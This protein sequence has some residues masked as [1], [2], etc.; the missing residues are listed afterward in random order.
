MSGLDVD[1]FLN[2]V[3]RPANRAFGLTSV[4]A[5]ELMLG[6]ALQESN[7]TYLAQLGNGP[8]LGVFQMEPNTHDDIWEN[9]LIYRPQLVE[10]M[11][12][13]TVTR[14]PGIMASNMLYAAAMCRMHYYR[15][16][17]ALPQA[18][19]INAQAAYWKEYYNTPLGAGTVEEY[20][21]NWNTK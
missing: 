13:I 12:Y 7:L 9:F 21:H 15:V 2:Y 8:A 3:I 6:T 17:A 18:G 20:I 5:E 16:K 11:D 4:A 14:S 1:Q 10:H 19:D